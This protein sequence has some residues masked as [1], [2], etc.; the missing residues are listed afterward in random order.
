MN[1]KLYFNN[2]TFL[3]PFHHKIYYKNLL[4]DWLLDIKDDINCYFGKENILV[5]D[6]SIS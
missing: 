6:L 2:I 1:Q 5:K 3:F 4:L